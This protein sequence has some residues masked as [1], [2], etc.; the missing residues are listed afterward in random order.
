MGV[1]GCKA[2]SIIGMV[3]ATSRVGSEEVSHAP[4]NR[5]SV[6]AQSRSKIRFLW[7]TFIVSRCST[8]YISN[9]LSPRVAEQ[10]P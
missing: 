8:R 2:F 5:Q 10:A 9:A 1:V 3:F 4:R 6:E 7:V